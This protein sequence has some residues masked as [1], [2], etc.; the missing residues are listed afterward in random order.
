MKIKLALSMLFTA[1]L[2]QSATVI[3]IDE[4]TTFEFNT[5]TETATLSS[6]KAVEGYDCLPYQPP[7]SANPELLTS[8]NN[9][10]GFDFGYYQSGTSTYEIR[11]QKFIALEVVT[12]VEGLKRKEVFEEPLANTNPAIYTVSISRC[13][14]D[15]SAQTTEGICVKTG[16]A[17][18]LN[19]STKIDANP[20]IECALEQGEKYYLNI[21]HSANPPYT[22]STCNFSDCGLLFRESFN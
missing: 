17:M 18:S 5:T 7:A 20:N 12:P 3:N 15:F 19:W 8:Y 22:T 21:I 16:Q 1:T 2:S 13:P 9:F 11:T 6:S 4:F 14:G 10:T